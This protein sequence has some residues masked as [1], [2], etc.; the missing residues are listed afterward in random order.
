[1]EK[2][3]IKRVTALLIFTPLMIWLIISCSSTSTQLSLSHNSADE[4]IALVEKTIPEQQRVEKV[5]KLGLEMI[6]LANTMSQQAEDMSKEATSLNENYKTTKEEMQK[7]LSKSIEVRNATFAKYRD[8]VFA[9]R[10]EVSADEWKELT[11]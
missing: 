9:M 11:K 10:S 5:K 7:V 2:K 4:W 8:V 3:S 6:D 1:M